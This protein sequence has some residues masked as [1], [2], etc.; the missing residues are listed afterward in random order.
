LEGNTLQNVAKEICNTFLG[1]KIEKDL[2]RLREL[3]SGLLRIDLLT[4]QCTLDEAQIDPLEIV[5][6]LQ[7]MLEPQLTKIGVR[8][9]DVTTA[10]LVTRFSAPSRPSRGNEGETPSALRIECSGRIEAF[11]RDFTAREV[12]ERK[13][14]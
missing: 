6:E 14:A 8:A 11:G 4:G 7:A 12:L 13:F 2:G 10:D 3:R 5:P 9:E 1:P